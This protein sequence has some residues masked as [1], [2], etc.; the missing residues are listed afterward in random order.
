MF[1]LYEELAEHITELT[2]VEST[3]LMHDTFSSTL[4]SVFAK[5]ES[6]GR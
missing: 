4:E 5:T 3:S 2:Q 1:K 6:L